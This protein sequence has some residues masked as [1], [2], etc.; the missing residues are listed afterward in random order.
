[1]PN[2]WNPNVMDAEMFAKAIASLHQFGFVDPVTV[3]ELGLHDYQ[4]IDGFHRVKM[5][6]SHS[7]LC[8]EDQHVPCA[9]IPVFNLGLVDE[10]V[11]KQLTIVL[12]E[13]RGTPDREKLTRLVT[14]LRA[15]AGDD[16]RS[17]REV[18]PFAPDKYEALA[19]VRERFD[20]VQGALRAKKDGKESQVERVWRLPR[21]I[22]EA[23][24]DAIAKAKTEGAASDAEALRVIAEHFIDCA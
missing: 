9:V 24:D 22:A 7:A 23:L 14:E 6:L 12:N 17:L 2:P 4:I 8:D 16:D 13:T 20:A 1:M 18:L 19:G 10:D 21:I 15:R 11:A 5:A 3:R